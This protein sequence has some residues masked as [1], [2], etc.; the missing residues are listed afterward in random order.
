VSRA[1]PCADEGWR[2]PGDT[3]RSCPCRVHRAIA[4]LERANPEHVQTIIP[5]AM[6]E[7]E[8]DAA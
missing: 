5:R 3:R 7:L 4:Q 2:R 6:R 8:R 1:L